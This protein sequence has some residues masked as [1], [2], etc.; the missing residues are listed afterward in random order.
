MVGGTLPLGTNLHYALFQNIKHQK[1]Q[2]LG[3]QHS[4][5]DH[6]GVQ[7]RNKFRLNSYKKINEINT[8]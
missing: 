7:A 8:S 3:I 2:F 4:N 1:K 6:R 5:F